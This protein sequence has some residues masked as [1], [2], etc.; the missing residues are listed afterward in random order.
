MGRPMRNAHGVVYPSTFSGLAGQTVRGRRCETEREPL[1]APRGLIKQFPRARRGDSADSDVITDS[2]SA[3]ALDTAVHAK[4][5]LR[6]G[7]HRPG[8]LPIDLEPGLCA[9]GND[10]AH[11]RH[12]DVQGDFIE[13]HLCPDPLRLGKVLVRIVECHKDI[14][15]EPTNVK[16]ATDLR[17]NGRQA[18]RGQHMH[19]ARSTNVPGGVE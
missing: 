17:A 8:D 13:H 18:R 1:R 12:F 10:A 3:G 16:F 9:A 6:P 15:S 2:D 7:G 19:C 11:G 14:R 4:T 5:P